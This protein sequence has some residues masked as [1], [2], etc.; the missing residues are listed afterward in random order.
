MFFIWLYSPQSEGPISLSTLLPNLPHLG[1]PC[2]RHPVDTVFS[3]FQIAPA[4][5]VQEP[6]CVAWFHAAMKM[7]ASPL[8][9]EVMVYTSVA[10]AV[11][12]AL[13]TL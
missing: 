5:V 4:S 9:V 3:C 1:A 11:G 13:P 7:L 10:P 12:R 6:S 8:V 2:A